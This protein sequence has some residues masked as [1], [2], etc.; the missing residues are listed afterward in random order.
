MHEW[1]CDNG[2]TPH[3]IVDATHDA[4][5]AP[6]EH[7]QKDGRIVLNA[8]PAATR[9]LRLGN[10]VITFEARFGGVPSH[11]EFPP[12]AVLGIYARETGQGMMFPNEDTPPADPPP[13]EQGTKPRLKVVK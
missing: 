5:K 2:L 12:A 1:M 8:G 9:G 3:L 7:V 10:D 13:G 11:L 4:V 6:R